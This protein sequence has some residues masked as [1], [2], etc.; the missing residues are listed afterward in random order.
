MIS[1]H[2][3]EMFKFLTRF[4]FNPFREV[5]IYWSICS[6][7][8]VSRAVR[9]FSENW[10]QLFGQLCKAPPGFGV[11]LADT[12]LTNEIG[13]IT[14]QPFLVRT[15]IWKESKMSLWEKLLAP[16]NGFCWI[17]SYTTILLLAKPGFALNCNLDHFFRA[18]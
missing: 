8:K 15:I 4:C 10:R 14:C 11:L 5:S 12:K 18:V 7:E 6:P 2:S 17:N 9:S 1:W 16:T 3:L 13:L